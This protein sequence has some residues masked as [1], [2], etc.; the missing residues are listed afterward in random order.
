M[1]F[2]EVAT[3]DLGQ[4]IFSA[5]D[6]SRQQIQ[7]ALNA[8]NSLQH[9]VSPAQRFEVYIAPQTGASFVV[10]EQFS[11]AQGP[12]GW[13]CVARDAAGTI[14]LHVVSEAPE[15]AQLALQRMDAATSFEGYLTQP[16]QYEVNFNVT[17]NA[18][19]FRYDGMGVQRKGWLLHDPPWGVPSVPR[20]LVLTHSRRLNAYLG[21]ATKSLVPNGSVWTQTFFPAVIATY[22]A[23]FN[24]N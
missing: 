9:S 18:P 5:D 15:P 24:R 20:E 21:V 14:E 13:P 6:L 10:P 11:I 4:M 7:F 1:V 8:A 2:Q 19:M 12:P 3:T 22:A 23:A 17:M 16:A